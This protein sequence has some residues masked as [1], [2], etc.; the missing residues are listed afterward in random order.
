MSDTNWLPDVHFG[1]AETPLPKPTEDTDPD[2]DDELL[3]ST[4]QD[5]IDMLGFDPR[6]DANF[7]ALGVGGAAPVPP[8]PVPPGAVVKPRIKPAPFAKD[9]KPSRKPRQP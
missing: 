7:M 4:P 6:D 2:P 5:V 1:S 8:E 3:P 9:A